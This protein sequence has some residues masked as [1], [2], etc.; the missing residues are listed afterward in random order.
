MPRI[1]RVC[2]VGYP[3]QADTIEREEPI[4]VALFNRTAICYNVKSW[5]GD[6]GEA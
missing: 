1:A 4:Q 3:H 6:Y 2:A 5:K